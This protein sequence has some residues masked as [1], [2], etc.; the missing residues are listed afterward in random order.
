MGLRGVLF[1]IELHVPLFHFVH[2]YL[3]YLVHFYVNTSGKG[4]L[5]DAGAPAGASSWVASCLRSVTICTFECA[6]DAGTA[7]GY[8]ASWLQ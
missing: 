1:S 5:C 8:H 2:V 6:G 4:R 3:V 7:A